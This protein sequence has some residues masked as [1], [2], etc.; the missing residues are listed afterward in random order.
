MSGGLI[1]MQDAGYI[2]GS[3]GLTLVVIAGFT[4]RVLRGGRR[5]ADQVDDDDKYWT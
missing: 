3:Y 2:V 1:A 5:L 4:W